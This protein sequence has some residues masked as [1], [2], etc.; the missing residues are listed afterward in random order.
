VTALLKAAMFWHDAGCAVIPAAADGTK[1][2]FGPWR[3]YIEQAPTAADQQHWFSGDEYDGLGIVCGLVSGGLEMFE[4]EGRAVQEGLDV[5]LAE[6]LDSHGL[7]DLWQ[8]IDNGYKERTPS[9]GAHWLYRVGGE[10]R[11][12]LKLAR[13]PATEQELADNPDEREKV[14]IE[15]R[16]EGG[17]T[18][19][20][21][22]GGRTHP[23]RGKW[24]RLAGSP[25]S[26]P[27]ITD[28]ERDALHAVAAML[29]TL[30]VQEAAPRKT[31]APRPDGE[32]RPGDDFNNRADWSDILPP[33]GWTE[34]KALGRTRTWTRPGKDARA[35]ISAT[36][37]RNDGDNLYVFSSSTV[38]ETEKAYSKFAAYTLL[39]HDGDWTAAARHLSTA[40]YGTQ[41]LLSVVPDLPDFTPAPPPPEPPTSEL[42]AFWTARPAL[43]HLRHFA[44]A[45]LTSPWAVL[46]VALTRVTT[47]APPALVLPPIVGSHASLN[48]FIALVGRSGGGK[49]AAEN[50]AADAL[51]LQDE[52]YTAPVGS[53]EGIAHLYAHREKGAVIRDRNA[54]MFT[55][56]EVDNLV[57]LSNRQSSTLMPQLRSAWSGERL[58]FSYADKTKA[59]PLERHSYRMCLVLGVQPGRSQPLLD[60]A[61]GGTP[62]RFIWLPTVDKDVPAITPDAPEPLTINKPRGPMFAGANGLVP[63]DVCATA[64]TTIIENRKAALRGEGDALDGHSLLARLKTAAALGLLDGRYGVTDEDWHLAGIVMAVSDHTRGEVVQYLASHASKLNQAKGAAE[65]MRAVAVAEQVVDAAVA[66][67]AATI[68]RRLRGWGERDGWATAAELRRAISSSQRQHFED[69]LDRLIA[70]GQ[71]DTNPANPTTYKWKE[72]GGK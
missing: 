40:G 48:L 47:T 30:P 34:G 11:G 27:T 32:I 39:N 56:P 15:T 43:T 33:H 67:C 14:L 68:G 31:A 3:R 58:G 18:I 1:R 61:D 38:F 42:E 37:G 7:G 20:A 10:A 29:D 51:T 70:A 60:D 28:D 17:F 49:G 62:Q 55:V 46:G 5:A 71:V 36:T 35:G 54:V 72:G 57:A 69:A 13:R 25:T 12:N 64:R 2:P 65:G 63:I 26:I 4:L 23:G 8:R 9:G 24:V 66:R 53:G 19:V 21:P 22:S 6:L 16:G 44:R 52:V 41:R 50:A 59:L 45:R